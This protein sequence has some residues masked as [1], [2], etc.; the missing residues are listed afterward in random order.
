MT[1]AR[2]ALLARM[3]TINRD[4]RTNDMERVQ[5]TTRPVRTQM[6]FADLPDYKKVMVQQLAGE[7]FG[8]ENPFYRAHDVG[9]GAT[10]VINGQ[11]LINFSSYDYL[12]LNHHGEVL[13]AA[14]DAMARYGMSASASRLVAGERPLHAELERALAGLY[15][16]DEAV[17]FVSGYL[18]NVAAISCLVAAPDL[19]IHDEFIHNSALAGIGLS[20]AARR[21][22]RHND[23]A[24]LEHILNTQSGQFRNILVI[25]EGVYSMD[26]DVTPLPDIIALK[27]SYGFWLMVDEAHALGVLGETGRGTFEHFGVDATDVDI[28][29]GTLSK[30][31]SSCGG[32]IAG[33]EALVTLMKARAGG[34]V[35]SVGLAPVLAGAAIASLAV[36]KREPERVAA[37]KANGRL[38]KQTAEAAGLDTGLSEGLSVVPVLVGDS[39]RAVQLSN[40]L[41]AQ[42]VNAMPIIYPAVPEG[43]ARLRFFITSAHTQDQIHE[44]VRLTAAALAR[45]REQ[46]FGPKAQDLIEIAA[47]LQQL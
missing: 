20:G 4:A 13:A 26:G 39:M 10:T 23:V 22:F 17:C 34:F 11:P 42:G 9:A 14:S 19:V 31:T 18:T 24:D 8:I 7:H 47:S 29:M 32:Y 1:G 6:G 41:L 5:T 35:Y 30:T 44:T 45:L 36:L 46:N 40:E 38:F 21:S 2:E 43:M 15:G 27:K 3:R 28:W 33:S 37:L 12:D 16:V 25:V